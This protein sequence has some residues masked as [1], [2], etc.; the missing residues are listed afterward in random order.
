MSAARQPASVALH[1]GDVDVK[2]RGAHLPM[3]GMPTDM[4]GETKIQKVEHS[5]FPRE[6][7][8]PDDDSFDSE[9]DR[10]VRDAQNNKVEKGG[11]KRLSPEQLRGVRAKRNTQDWSD[12]ESSSDESGGAAASGTALAAEG[13]EEAGPSQQDHPM[14]A[15]TPTK[16]E[17]LSAL[18]KLLSETDRNSMSINS[19]WALLATKLG[20]DKGEIDKTWLRLEVDKW[21]VQKRLKEG[22]GAAEPTPAETGGAGEA[23]QSQQDDSMTG[24]QGGSD[25]KGDEEEV[26]GGR[27]ATDASEETEA[28]PAK[29]SRIRISFEAKTAEEQCKSIRSK[30]STAKSKFFGGKNGEMLKQMQPWDW[31]REYEAIKTQFNTFRIRATDVQEV[32]NGPVLLADDGLAKDKYTFVTDDDKKTPRISKL[33]PL[34]KEYL[35]EIITYIKAVD[36]ALA[37]SK[38]NKS[39][40]KPQAAAAS[41]EDDAPEVKAARDELAAAKAE[42]KKKTEKAAEVKQEMSGSQESKEAFTAQLKVVLV[43]REKVNAAQLELDLE[44][45]HAEDK[46]KKLAAEAA[47]KAAAEAEAKAQ[48]KAQAKAE[49]QAEA[50]LKREEKLRGIQLQLEKERAERIVS[51]DAVSEEQKTEVKKWRVTQ[52]IRPP[53]L[54]EKSASAIKEYTTWSVRADALKILYTKLSVTLKAGNAPKEAILTQRKNTLVQYEKDYEFDDGNAGDDRYAGFDTAQLLEKVTDIQRWVDEKKIDSINDDYTA[55]IASQK[56]LSEYNDR[57]AH[58]SLALA[59]YTQKTQILGKE[60]ATTE[61]GAKKG[62]A[63]GASSGTRRDDIQELIKTIRDTFGEN[64]VPSEEFTEEDEAAYSVIRTAWKPHDDFKNS[65]KTL[66]KSIKEGKGDT[67]KL[68][69]LK[70]LVK[71]YST[72]YKLETQDVESNHDAV[73]TAA[74]KMIAVAESK[75]KEIKNRAGYMTLFRKKSNFTIWEK[76]ARMYERDAREVGLLEKWA[77][78]G[79]KAASSSSTS[80][81]RSSGRNARGIQFFVKKYAESYIKKRDKGKK[82]PLGDSEDVA[83]STRRKELSEELIKK[84]NTVAPG[85]EDDETA[86]IASVAKMASKNYNMYFNRQDK[87]MQITEELKVVAQLE[88][89]LDSFADKKK[90]K[91]STITLEKWLEDELALNETYI[92]A[93]QQALANRDTAA[94]KGPRV[95]AHIELVE[96]LTKYYL[97]KVLPTD[98]DADIVKI[99]F[100]EGDEEEGDEEEGDEEDDA[101]EEAIIGASSMDVDKDE[102]GEEDDA[103][104][105]AITGASSM[106]V[107]KDEGGGEDDAEEEA[108]TGAS[109]MNVD[110]DEGGGADTTQ[111]Y[112]R[113]QE[114]KHLESGIVAVRDAIKA[115]QSPLKDAIDSWEGAEKAYFTLLYPSDKNKEDFP[116]E[117]EKE[118]RRVLEYLVLKAV[119]FPRNY[120][121]EELW[122]KEHNYGK[123][124]F[125]EYERFRSD[126]LTDKRKKPSDL[127]SDVSQWSPVQAYWPSKDLQRFYESVGGWF[128]K[129]GGGA[130][131]T[132]SS[133]EGDKVTVRASWREK[134]GKP[135]RREDTR[136]VLR[137]RT[138][139]EKKAAA[140]RYHTRDAYRKWLAQAQILVDS[141]SGQ[142]ADINTSNYRK[143]FDDSY[144]YLFMKLDES[145]REEERTA[146]V[147]F[148][149]A[150]AVERAAIDRD[151]EDSEQLQRRI[152]REK[153]A[154]KRWLGRI[155]GATISEWNSMSKEDRSKL[156]E[157]FA[158]ADSQKKIYHQKTDKWKDVTAKIVAIRKE[159]KQKEAAGAPDGEG[160]VSMQEASYEGAEGGEGEEEEGEE[161]GKATKEEKMRRAEIRTS[162]AESYARKMNKTELMGE[163]ESLLSYQTTLTKDMAKLKAEV[164]EEEEKKT[165]RK[166]EKLEE[167]RQK[168]LTRYADALSILEN[169]A[170]V[171]ADMFTA[172]SMTLKRAKVHFEETLKKMHDSTETKS[173]AYEK[174]EGEWTSAL[175]S[176]G[177]S[178]SKELAPLTA[179]E[180]KHMRQPAKNFDLDYGNESKAIWS[181]GSASGES[182]ESGA[183]PVQAE[184]NTEGAITANQ[185]S[186]A[187]GGT[188][189]GNLTERYANVDNPIDPPLNVGGAQTLWLE[190]H[191]K[192][193]H[194]RWLAALP[195]SLYVNVA[196][197]VAPLCPEGSNLIDATMLREA[198]KKLLPFLGCMIDYK[199]AMLFVKERELSDKKD[200][201]PPETFQRKFEKSL[202]DVTKEL[203]VMG[204]YDYD[205]HMAQLIIKGEEGSLPGQL[206]DPQPLFLALRMY[207]R[208]RVGKS[209]TSILLGSIVK[210]LGMIVVYSVAPNKSMPI[211]E[212]E[213]KLEKLGWN[214]TGDARVKWNCKRI[215]D[216]ASKNDECTPA[217]DLDMVIYSSE[218]PKK[219]AAQMGA[220]LA[221]W[222][223]SNRTVFHIRDEAQLHAKHLANPEVGCHKTDAPAPFILQ[224]L[225]H[226]YGN[227]HGLNCNVT[228]THFPTLLEEQMWG[229]IGSVPQMQAKHI[230]PK[231]WADSNALSRHMGT[232]FLPYLVPAL[233]P[234]T[235]AGYVGIEDVVAWRGALGG[236]QFLT[237]G[238]ISARPT[239][240]N[241]TTAKGS[242]KIAEL[243]QN[244]TSSEEDAIKELFPGKFTSGSARVQLDVHEIMEL[245]Q[246]LA[247]KEDGNDGE[248]TEIK[249]TAE[250][251]KDNAR[252][253]LDKMHAHFVQWLTD[254]AFKE[255]PIGDWHNAPVIHGKDEYARDEEINRPKEGKSSSITTATENLSHFKYRTTSIVPTYIAAVN[256]FVSDVGMISF[257]KY[258]GVAAH[259]NLIE[260]THEGVAFLLIA[261]EKWSVDSLKAQGIETVQ[262][263]IDVV[264]SGLVTKSDCNVL[265]AT[266]RPS[267]NAGK[268]KNDIVFDLIFAKD[269]EAAIIH[270]YDEYKISKCAILGYNML[271]AGLTLQVAHVPDDCKA[272][273]DPI[274]RENSNQLLAATSIAEFCEFWNADGWHGKLL[275][276]AKNR[277]A[278]FADLAKQN[279]DPEDGNTM[280]KYFMNSAPSQPEENVLFLELTESRAW[281][282]HPIEKAIP[283]VLSKLLDTE[284]PNGTNK[285]EWEKLVKVL[286]TGTPSRETIVDLLA[287]IKGTTTLRMYCTSHIAMA[288]VSEN[289]SA[290]DQQLQMLGR[291]FVDLKGFVKP[292]GWK[293]YLLGA[294]GLSGRLMSYT[295]LEDKLSKIGLGDTAVPMYKA[296][297]TD[298]NLSDLEKKR[299]LGKIGVRRV[300]L[301]SILGLTYELKEKK[302]PKY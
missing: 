264:P 222:R 128:E 124:H 258:F 291:S 49:K 76:A 97:E 2:A 276:S 192:D 122:N 202:Q 74:T 185:S 170:E 67:G 263:S 155:S 296:L 56:R 197:A 198:A 236:R 173:T 7:E 141:T 121:N 216:A 48:A 82:A 86:A 220:L 180:I 232:K 28:D 93:Q 120:D 44:T 153:S 33:F 8:Q 150:R 46:Q 161:G 240:K 94:E 210:R 183:E 164:K 231:D 215:E 230:P 203:N 53:E 285:E 212:I 247:P 13:A 229:F 206:Y 109:S 188:D 160:N 29:P 89:F 18:N 269:A 166:N 186:Y 207:A 136:G 301:A 47:A 154:M 221:Y 116:D 159:L 227:R 156:I 58:P 245:E 255:K 275:R 105:K 101:E 274:T 130:W 79:A 73:I 295:N 256:N 27:A 268:E 84:V 195:D 226:Y 15:A 253:N 146:F 34:Q 62:S 235:P 134:L 115:E 243:P 66:L 83:P 71:K 286:Q 182:G 251:K 233:R 259:K 23:G 208:P 189:R 292:A 293:I 69:E 64:S 257:V 284:L 52:D 91:R 225:R 260:G 40:T 22:D 144:A 157:Q 169:K 104:E 85:D 283:S 194:K 219:D 178:D 244:S 70:S 191:L 272:G 234:V 132:I 103:E 78:R 211:Q 26:L 50:A 117:W 294:A 111:S 223:L 87:A 108:I 55:A 158:T 57:E 279:K 249:E 261:S 143:D 72:D 65:V 218:T 107:D 254:D 114:Q 288:Q 96:Q 100:R 90:M 1:V 238:N 278:I 131:Y 239:N 181:D 300:D 299:L 287:G 139:G 163:L 31:N 187:V 41:T 213:G 241:G 102:G 59:Y 21:E 98:E 147:T 140:T 81:V 298:I 171:D 51:D 262:K 281:N 179:D 113:A 167:K 35:G 228:A 11:G 43:A 176:T 42:L 270:A 63:G 133:D 92:L 36:T 217:D 118:K 214:S 209:A 277:A 265:L 172:Y 123:R 106:D 175:Q 54:N 224:H 68:E 61:K 204:R 19:L 60:A 267:K 145:K 127:L 138:P 237:F 135:V 151:D 38:Y 24:K 273:G 32:E 148:S 271:R 242:R 152:R 165:N 14:I 162:D 77:S 137:V 45:L 252:S 110:K 266:Y 25:G 112:V 184:S 4:P 5:E 297:R 95:K 119:W 10:V 282:H 174:R 248:Y 75:I 280:I 196:E 12:D 6:S 99:L 290:L 199:A 39:E 289:D 9:L 30:I 168:L 205:R 246:H 193:M 250:Q 126:I 142:R 129:P 80:A 302:K 37:G 125:D 177:S 17:K 149:I 3:L 20:C 200:V 16:E 201:L 88:I 190:G